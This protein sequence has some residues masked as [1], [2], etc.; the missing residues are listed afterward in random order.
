[1]EVDPEPIVDCCRL[2]ALSCLFVAMIASTVW[3]CLIA[4]ICR[5]WYRMICLSPCCRVSFDCVLVVAQAVLPF[6]DDHVVAVAVVAVERT[7]HASFLRRLR[8]DCIPY[9]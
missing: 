4:W 8:I 9:R 5:I 2:L 1:V 6:H 7:D 3:T